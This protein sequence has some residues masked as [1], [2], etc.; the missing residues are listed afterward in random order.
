MYKTETWKSVK[1]LCKFNSKYEIVSTIEIREGY[2]IS[3][4]GRLRYKNKIRK[5]KPEPKGYIQD[6]LFG[7]DGRRYRFKRHQIVMQTFD[8][9]GYK[10]GFTV[11]HKDRNT[12]NNFFDNLRWASKETQSY[13]R[14]NKSY[15]FKKVICLNDLKIFDS[16]QDAEEYYKLT[17]NTVSRVARGE[18]KSIHGFRFVYG[19]SCKRLE[20]ETAQ[21]N[22]FDFIGG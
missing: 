20:Q 9:S 18:R 14:E 11:D 22:L 17:K 1:I 13:N 10:N 8:F 16:C 15:K 2:F 21:M 7:K 3:S 19:D 5:N 4:S 6:F 12:E